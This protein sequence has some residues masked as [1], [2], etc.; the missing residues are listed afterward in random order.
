MS[1]EQLEGDPQ[2]DTRADIYALGLLF[3]ELVLGRPVLR[4]VVKNELSW[5][6]NAKRVRAFSFPKLAR[7]GYSRE[8]DW[9]MR[10]ACAP[11]RRERY[12]SAR[13]MLAD[14]KAL[15]KGDIIKAGQKPLGYLSLKL[16]RRHWLP[17]VF[18]TL[19][20]TALLSIAVLNAQMAAQ[21]NEA[22]QEVEESL[23]KLQLAEAQAKRDASDAQLVSGI[24]A[25]RNENFGKAR[26]L[27]RLALEIWPENEDA[28]YTLSFLESTHRFAEKVPHDDV[29]FEV[30][31]IK[32]THSGFVLHGAKG[33][34]ATLTIEVPEKTWE[35]EDILMEE[36]PGMV[37]F[38]SKESGQ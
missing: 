6:E 30:V 34:E 10:K 5:S 11:N 21:E 1:P 24:A 29:E 32:E 7:M 8:W 25:F 15:Q 26:E 27:L 23:A 33:E 2:I 22:R 20:I 36:A 17:V 9:V 3:Y 31:G 13:E 19:V 35:I 14:V 4:E 12:E 18:A 38:R 37:T 16:L 28:Q